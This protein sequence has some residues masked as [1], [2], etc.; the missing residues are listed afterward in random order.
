M[1]EKWCYQ[2]CKEFLAILD[3]CEVEYNNTEEEVYEEEELVMTLIE[4]NNNDEKNNVRPIQQI[5]HTYQVGMDLWD[6][7]YKEDL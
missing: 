3:D 6:Q 1:A 7:K 4:D 5:E 2:E